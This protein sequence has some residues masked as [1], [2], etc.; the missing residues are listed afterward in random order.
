MKKLILV[1]LSI[2]GITA[3]FAQPKADEPGTHDHKYYFPVSLYGDSLAFNRAIP[4]LAEKV[5]ADFSD[6]EKKNF[7][8][9]AGY[10][11]LS[12]DHK[13]VLEM[14]D[15]IEKKGDMLSGMELKSYAIAKMKEK[16]KA[17]SFE[18]TF[19]QDYTASYNQ[20]TFR[21]KVSA[22]LFDTAVITEYR[23]GYI[24]LKDK[25]KKNNSD[26]L[27]YD[28]AKTLLDNLSVYLLFKEVYPLISPLLTDKKYLQMFPAIKGYKWAGVVPVQN[29]DDKLDPNMQYKLLMELTGFAPKGQES[30][31]QKEING[32]IGEVARK[33]NLHVAGGVPKEKMDVVIIVH[34]GALF[35]LLNNEKYKQK[36]QVDNP[37]ITL[38]KELQD[39]GAKFIVC[40]QAMTFLRLEKEDLLPGIKE[41]ISAQTVLSMYELK[42]YKVY[43]VTLD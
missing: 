33:I 1:I 42:G 26:S 18:Q 14:V 19:K 32:G 29:I 31:A 27:N 2:T 16:E 39:F 3:T 38:I 13:K 6:K 37:N 17:G 35:A 23:K 21:K 36:Y 24:D 7:E 9:S 10:Y 15:S 20:L 40:G 5:I 25:F 34:A 8:K 11:F 30:T 43:D 28:D 12:Q 41:A 4:S 22:A